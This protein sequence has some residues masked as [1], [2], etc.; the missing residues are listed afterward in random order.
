MCSIAASPNSSVIIGSKRCR[1]RLRRKAISRFD[2]SSRQLWPR[3]RRNSCRA[4]RGGSRAAAAPLRRTRALLFEK[5]SA[6]ECPKVRECRCREKCA[7]APSPPDRRECARSQSFVTRDLP[8]RQPPAAK[9]TVAQ[10]T[11]ALPPRRRRSRKYDP[12]TGA[13]NMQFE[14][15]L[16]RQFGDKALVFVRL[17]SAQLVIDMRDRRHDPQLG[18]QLQQQAKQSHGIRPAGNCRG[19]AVPSPNRTAASELSSTAALRVRAR[20]NGTAVAS[21]SCSVAALATRGKATDICYAVPQMWGA[22]SLDCQVSGAGH[23]RPGLRAAGDGHVLGLPVSSIARTAVRYRRSR[24]CHAI[25]RWHSRTTTA[26]S[27]GVRA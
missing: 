11:R 7:A 13:S 1:T 3:S 27:R 25:M 23:A 9:K 17:F 16:P 12:S 22:F 26:P 6:D 8:P 15:V 20:R 18:A 21:A 14:P 4:T 24:R 10:F 19:H 5:R 2:E